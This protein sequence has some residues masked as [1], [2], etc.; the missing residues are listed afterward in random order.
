MSEWLLYRDDVGIGGPVD[1]G[2]VLDGIADGRVPRDMK[3]RRIDDTSWRALSHIPVFALAVKMAPASAAT[4][5]RGVLE[6]FAEAQAAAEAERIDSL[7]PHVREAPRPIRQVRRRGSGGVVL[8]IVAGAVLGIVAVI[9]VTRSVPGLRGPAP[10]AAVAQAALAPTFHRTVAALGASG[11]PPEAP[12]AVPEA[13]APVPPPAAPPPRIQ[14][15]RKPAAAPRA[16]SR[17]DQPGF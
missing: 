13:A 9:G 14:K 4:P 17:L 2:L 10:A 15:K 7:R 11:S 5:V 8:G 12:S 3:V 16:P 1:S 6:G